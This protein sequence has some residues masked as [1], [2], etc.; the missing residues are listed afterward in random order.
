[1]SNVPAIE[2]EQLRD[3]MQSE[4][5]PILLDVREKWE[6]DLC[7]I[8]GNRLIPLATLG[9][10]LTGLP[11]D[12]PIV[13]HCHHGGRSARAVMILQ[14]KGYT[15]VFSLTGGIHAWSQRIDQCVKT[16]E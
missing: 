7:Q 15:Q 9:D 10:C 14:E 8:P 2:V 6:S 13:V 4:N 16:Y 5:P 3:K 12:Q 11:K 1:M